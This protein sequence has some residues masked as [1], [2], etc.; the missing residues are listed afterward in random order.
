MLIVVLK[1]VKMLLFCCPNK[2]D[3]MLLS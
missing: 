2:T 3:K 1:A